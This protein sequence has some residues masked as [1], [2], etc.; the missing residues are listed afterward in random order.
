M[1]PYLY[2]R[3]ANPNDVKVIFDPVEYL[4][5]HGLTKEHCTLIELVDHPA[6]TK[7]HE[8]VQESLQRSIK[9]GNVEW[10]TFRIQTDGR[11]VQ[12]R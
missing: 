8:R 11:I 6:E 4:V 7:S 9:S 12:E 3:A 2:D 5:F 1:S 10:Q